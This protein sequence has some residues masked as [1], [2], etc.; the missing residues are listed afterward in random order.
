MHKKLNIKLTPVDVE[1]LE[2]YK[3]LCDGLSV[4]LGE[5]SEIV[6]HSLDNYEHSVIKISNGFHTGRTEGSPITDLALDMLDHI[7]ENNGVNYLSY[8]SE[9]KRGTPLKS[10]TIAIPGEGGRIIGL[11][12]I[13]YYLDTPIMNVLN[14]LTSVQDHKSSLNSVILQENFSTSSD[15]LIKEIVNKVSKQVLSDPNISLVNKNKEII[16]RLNSRGVFKMK[17]AVQHCA[18]ILGISK[19]TVYLHLRHLNNLPD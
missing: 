13:N 17:E 5:G 15:D 19:N 16:A 11:L 1:I 9:N 8:L 18:D 7:F 14:D 10:A 6:L 4:Y 12:C 2:S 3:T